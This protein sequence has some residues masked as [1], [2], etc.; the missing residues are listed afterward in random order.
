MRVRAFVAPEFYQFSLYHF[1]AQPRFIH[2]V[3]R[4]SATQTYEALPITATE[5]GV[6]GIG[7]ATEEDGV[8]A[9][10]VKALTY[11]SGGPRRS[12]C[13]VPRFKG[14]AFT[15]GDR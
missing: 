14:F 2:L 12:R 13:L 8:R 6:A 11:H 4:Q 5:R 1:R 9:N 7:G 15:V 3:A 10:V